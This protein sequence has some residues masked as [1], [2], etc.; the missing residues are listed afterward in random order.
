[1]FCEYR[2]GEFA[3]RAIS[4]ADVYAR[5][6]SMSNGVAVTGGVHGDE[7]S[8][9]MALEP[10]ALEGFATFGPC[11]AWGLARG[12]RT[13]ESGQDLNRSF[14]HDDCDEASR[15]RAFLSA[16]RPSLVLDLHEDASADAPYFIQY[17]PDHSTGASLVRA[18]RPAWSFAPR[19]RF[20]PVFGRDGVLRPPAWMIAIVGA[21]RRWPLVY[22]VWRTLRVPGVV[23]EVP[24]QWEIERRVAFHVEAARAARGIVAL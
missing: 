6:A 3:R 1:M 4:A 8:G 10:L 5:V 15:V 21:S 13:L 9:A 12:R 20:G 17:A 22:W 2:A 7:P 11:N 14:A 23:I 16:H 19:P 24:G 18:L